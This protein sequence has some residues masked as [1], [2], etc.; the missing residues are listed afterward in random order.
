MAKE[1]TGEKVIFELEFYWRG[2]RRKPSVGMLFE[3][4][5]YEGLPD[6]IADSEEYKTFNK[7]AKEFCRVLVEAGEL[8]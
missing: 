6:K 7:S 2:K 8:D 5:N 4:D 3:S 1:L